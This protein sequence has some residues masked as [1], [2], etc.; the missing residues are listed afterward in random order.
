MT[1]G[2]WLRI[3]IFVITYEMDV[4]KDARESADNK[5]SIVCYN[6]SIRT[7]VISKNI[8]ISI[9]IFANKKKM[10]NNAIGA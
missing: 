1:S 5:S 6:V 2:E 8:C 10:M 4:A 3:V 9:W 7:I